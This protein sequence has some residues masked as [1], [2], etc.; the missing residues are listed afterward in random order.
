MTVASILPLHML[1]G[2]SIVGLRL[3]DA[4]FI[5]WLICHSTTGIP[6]GCS[7]LLE[8]LLMLLL[9]LHLLL[10][11]LLH[12]GRLRLMSLLG[13]LLHLGGLLLLK[14]HG[15]S[16]VLLHWQLLLLLLLLS[17]CHVWYCETCLRTC[18][19]L[20]LLLVFMHRLLWI[21]LLLTGRRW[22]VLIHEGHETLLDFDK[23]LF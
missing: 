19:C 3:G 15:R 6:G 21:W 8:L 18:G 17:R 1:L 10:L 9:L 13:H 20:H 12:Q 23:F 22:W 11:H 5:G 4:A 2:K 14:I 16:Q 7:H